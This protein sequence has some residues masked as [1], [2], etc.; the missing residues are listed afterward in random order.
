M[1]A[2]SI[3]NFIFYGSTSGSGAQTPVAAVSD[4][5]LPMECIDEEKK[6][7]TVPYCVIA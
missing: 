3:V 5:E 4:F 2:Q 7:A 6:A 1:D